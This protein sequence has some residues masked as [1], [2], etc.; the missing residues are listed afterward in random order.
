MV[1]DWSLGPF[2]SPYGE[3]N[4]LF[5]NDGKGDSP[6]LTVQRGFCG[7]LNVAR[8]LV[9]GDIDGD[10]AVDLLVTTI[11]G[12]AG[13]RTWLPDAVTGST[14]VPW[15]WPCRRDALGAQV[16]VRAGGRDYLASFHPAE[17]YLCSSEPSAHYG[18][19][20][21]T[22]IDAI[23]IRWPDGQRKVF[24]N[25]GKGYAVDRRLTLR[26]GDGHLP[27]REGEMRK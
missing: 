23:D 6:N 18:L 8:G 4:Q 7:R 26:K 21:A 16:R 2:W 5:R 22:H 24:D 9:R 20:G 11:G 14:C 15:I 13:S 1:T 27:T 12:P 19:G 10:G 25:A 17:S 3:R